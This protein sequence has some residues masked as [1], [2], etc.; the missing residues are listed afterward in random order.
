MTECTEA[1]GKRQLRFDFG[2]GKGVVGEFDGG[3]ISSDGGL[4][5][6]RQADDRLRLTEQAAFCL[7]DRRRSG[8]IRHEMQDLLRQRL[9]MIASGYEDAN[10]AEQLRSDPMHKLCVGREPESG[11]DLASQPT[12]SRLENRVTEEEL[13]LLQELLLHLYIQRFKRAPRKVVLDIDT[14]CD[15]VHGYQQLSF[16]NG[17]Y[18]TYCYVP[19]F[20]FDQDGYPL[21]AR[22]RAGNAAPAEGTMR[23]LRPV[24]E[25]LKAAWP[26]VKIELKADAA[27]GLPELYEYCEAQDITYFIG[28]KAH[29]GLK[30]N[31]QDLV[32]LVWREFESL[33]GE[34]PL[35]PKTKAWRQ[36]EERIRFASKD[37]G[38]MQE[39]FE[40]ERRD[41][42]IIVRC[43]VTDD[44]TE[45]RYIVTNSQSSRPK[46]IYETKYCRRCQCEN[47]IKELKDLKCDR[48]SCQEF[49]ANQFRLLLHTLAYILVREVR[50]RLPRSARQISARTLISR[51]IKVGVLVRESVRRISLHWSSSYPWQ[52]WF[53]ALVLGFG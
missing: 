50:E 52:E 31:S 45:L 11:A 49:S 26:G 28:A 5:L 33:Y 32:K 2:L 20:I 16:L 30:S 41:R 14:T 35:Q 44:G 24:V 17:F 34:P 3:R 43:D 9:Y 29:H 48:L 12:L 40:T 22:L 36:R 42:R 38:R 7:G 13:E 21:A 15:E 19:M 27:F 1:Q 53:R 8:Q 47:W 51:F 37:E 46:W 6:L 39:R 4:V 18:N 10:D 23:C 25:S